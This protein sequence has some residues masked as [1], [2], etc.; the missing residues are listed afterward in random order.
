MKR[1]YYIFSI[2]RIRRQ[3]NTLFFEK[4]ADSEVEEPAQASDEVLVDSGDF[5]AERDE[6]DHVQKRV[7]P[8]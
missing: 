8:V 6:R 7:I 3:Q 2:Y 4:A 5:E 1:P